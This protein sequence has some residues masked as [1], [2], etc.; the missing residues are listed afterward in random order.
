MTL[1]PVICRRFCAAYR[2]TLRRKWTSSCGI[3]PAKSV[4][5]QAAKTLLENSPVE[6]AR[7]YNLGSLPQPAQRG[8]TQFLSKFGHCGVAEIDLGMPR[9]SDDPTYIL[10]V[11]ANYLRLDNPEM[12]PNAQFARGAAAAEGVIEMLAGR[13]KRRRWQRERLVRFALGRARQLSGLHEIPKCYM[14]FVLA[15]V[16]RELTIVGTDLAGDGRINAVD[17]VFFLDLREVRAAIQV[18]MKD[19][20]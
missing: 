12:A 17:D 18:D 3:W 8:L 5:T 13:A 15:A 6:L 9:W 10:G 1:S 16:R 14:V 2:T 4:R 20:V 7:Q 19:R 11:L